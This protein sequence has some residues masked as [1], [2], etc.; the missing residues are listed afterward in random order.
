MSVQFSRLLK[1]LVLTFYYKFFIIFNVM[2]PHFKNKKCTINSK[3]L[4]WYGWVKLSSFLHFINTLE[5]RL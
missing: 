2:L 1:N 4:C 3:V 5:K